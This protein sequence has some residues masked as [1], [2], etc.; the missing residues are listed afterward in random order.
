MLPDYPI[1]DPS[2]DKLNRMTFSQRVA[3]VISSRYDSDGI[4][5][6]IYG[7][8]GEGKTTVLNFIEMSFKSDESIVCVRFNPWLFRDEEEL[9]LGFFETLAH[10]LQKK[11][12]TITE[13]IGNIIREFG[14]IIT[15][16]SLADSSGTLRISGNL[17]EKFGNL[18]SQVDLE[19]RKDRI[20][21]ILEKANKKLVIFIDDIDRLDKFEVQSI[22][23]LVKISANFKNTTYLLAFD[24]K[25]V[26]LALSERYGSGD[27]EAGRSFLEKIIQVPLA[28]PRVSN[29]SLQK[30]CFEFINQA[31]RN[32]DLKLT[33]EEISRFAKCFSE[34]LAIQLKNPRLAQRYANTVSFYISILRGEVNHVD[35]LLIEGVKTFY[36]NLYSAISSKPRYFLNEFSNCGNFKEIK[37]TITK[38]IEENI[39]DLSQ[40]AQACAKKLLQELF[41]FLTGILGNIHHGRDWEVKWTQQ[42]RIASSKYF[43]RYFSYS[44]PENE[45]SDQ[46]LST[47]LQ[48]LSEANVNDIKNSIKEI[49]NYQGAST[50]LFLTEIFRKIEN[51]SSSETQALALALAEVGSY[52][53]KHEQ[54]SYLGSP[55]RRSAILV[56]YL[57][58]KIDDSDN[59]LKLAKQVLESSDSIY[60]ALE[61]FRWM[62]V[63]KKTNDSEDSETLFSESDVNFLAQ[64][65][66]PK[67]RQLAQEKAIDLKSSENVQILFLFWAKWSSKSETNSYLR[68]YFET[69]PSSAIDFIRL[70][71]PT[72]QSLELSPPY[73]PTGLAFKGEFQQENYDSIVSIVDAEILIEA[74]EKVYGEKFKSEEI[75]IKADYQSTEELEKLIYYQFLQI[76]DRISSH[77]D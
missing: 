55:F 56:S 74:L 35:L 48:K 75:K 52:F 22:F 19:E 76:H 28:L 26:A 33:D 59:R 44:I 13:D 24:E 69:N 14:K 38:Y 77:T 11:L 61:C 32:I 42:K 67:I 71:A 2:L 70:Y 57:L 54:E 29:S 6:G 8:W 49:T 50:D 1:S 60:F 36:P 58:Q 45:I 53:P 46:E 31:L 27:L 17:F 5:I 65:V 40:E 30:L 47:F 10:T 43:S 9:L 7:D 16:L 15:P 12:T 25:K 37:I 4:V 68:D 64:V 34:G 39:S 62:K 51:F 23:K 73:R 18:F 66:I 41:P 3:E 21:K 72:F 20:G 63:I